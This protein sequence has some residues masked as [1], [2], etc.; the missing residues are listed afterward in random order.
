MSTDHKSLHEFIAESVDEELRAIKEGG[1]AARTRSGLDGRA[2]LLRGHQR[3]EQAQHRSDAKMPAEPPYK[4]SPFTL[5]LVEQALEASAESEALAS[6]NLDQAIGDTLDR[7][8]KRGS[9]RAWLIMLREV[10]KGLGFDSPEWSAGR[11]LI[12]REEAIGALRRLCAAHGDNDW[13]DVL[14]LADIINNHLAPHLDGK[15]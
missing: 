3:Y 1:F 14:H 12:E 11:W 4:V 15:K 9:R 5:A 2:L 7:A 8:A 13:P 10:L 6:A